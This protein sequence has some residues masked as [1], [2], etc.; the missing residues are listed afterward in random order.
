MRNLFLKLIRLGVN[1]SDDTNLQAGIDWHA[2]QALAEHQGLSAIVVDGIDKLSVNTR[3][4]K[5]QLL[6]WIGQ[7]MREE[8][9]YAIQ[10]KASSELSLLLS[11]EGIRTYVLKGEMVAECYPRPEHR[12][13]VDLD[14]FLK[15]ISGN[16]DVWEAGNAIVEQAGYRVERDFYKNSTWFLPGLTVENH[17]WLTPFRGNKRLAALEKLLQSLLKEDEGKDVIEGTQLC[18]PPIMVSSLFLIEHAYSH[19]LHEG[20]TWRHVLDWIMF[21]RKHKGEIDWK[22]LN[23]WIDEFGFRRFYDSFVRL[24]QYLLGEVSESELTKK[25]QMMLDDVWAELD[26]HESVRG[27]GGKLALVG[28]TWRARWK[29]REFTEISWLQALC[30]Q[31]KGFLF[32]KEPKLS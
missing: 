5:T 23:A 17:R 21:S 13:S 32:M 18:R 7:V 8:Q 25:E 31:V 22:Q 27:I 11:K 28:N 29:Y 30:I 3:P 9:R 15:S 26:L 10:R 20:L 4:P 12:C 14:C 16:D 6:P 2:I 1:I 19:F 24:G